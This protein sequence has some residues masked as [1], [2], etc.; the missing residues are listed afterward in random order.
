MN[1]GKTLFAH[2]MDFLPWLTFNCY[3]AHYGGDKGVRTPSCAEQFRVM[4][5]AQLTYR[6]SL[7]DIEA[8]LSAQASKL[9]HTGFREPIRRSTLADANES[10]LAQPCRL[11]RP[12]EH[13]GKSALRQRGLEAGIVEH[14]V[15]PRFDHH[16]SLSVG[17]F[18]GTLSE[19][20]GGGQD[21]HAAR[22]A[23]QHPQFHPRFGRQ[24]ARRACAGFA[25]PGGRCNHVMDRGHV[26]FARLYRLHL[27]G[28]FFVTRAKSN[29]K[30][31][32]VYSARTERSAGILCDQTIALVASTRSRIAPRNCAGYA[33]TTQKPARRS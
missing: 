15:C 18:V 2:L 13:P 33:S 4:A 9:Y 29:L 30:A 20:Q 8:S 19:G 16:R 11:R 3:V 14:G 32:R 24:V 12:P 10:R 5:F 27:A 7:H 17:V 23:R 22:L 21:A 26:D 28:A 1:A 31:H 25:D 6:E